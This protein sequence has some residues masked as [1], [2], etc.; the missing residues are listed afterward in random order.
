M[1]DKQK[2]IRNAQ[3]WD[4]LD[5]YADIRDNMEDTLLS[6]QELHADIDY[7]ME[8][9]TEELESLQERLDEC[10]GKLKRFKSPSEVNM[11]LPKNEVSCRSKINSAFH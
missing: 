2:D 3:I 6:F 9:I 8:Q 11:R 1:Q 4:L 10:S 5:A 7:A